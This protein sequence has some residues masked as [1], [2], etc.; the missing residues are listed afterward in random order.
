M[1][2]G[3]FILTNSQGSIVGLSIGGLLALVGL[4]WMV[5]G[6][7]GE[8]IKLYKEIVAPH[9]TKTRNGTAILILISILLVYLLFRY[10]GV[11]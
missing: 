9:D 8:G 5:I 3:I 2:G 11:I 1:L 4:V 7:A 10:F 6:T